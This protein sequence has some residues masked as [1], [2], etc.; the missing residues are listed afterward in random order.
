MRHVVSMRKLALPVAAAMSL[1]VGSAFA[2]EAKKADVDVHNVAA[3]GKMQDSS[4]PS[5]VGGIEMMQAIN[6]KSPARTKDEF[7]IGKKI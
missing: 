6:P 7:E 5:P 2:Q 4:G 3:K 1:V